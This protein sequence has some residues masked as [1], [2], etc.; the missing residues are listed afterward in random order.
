MLLYFLKVLLIWLAFYYCI[1]RKCISNYIEV[2]LQF[3][4]LCQ[5]PVVFLHQAFALLPHCLHLSI[6]LSHN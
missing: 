6:G 5:Q 3:V 4:V 1:I 2:Y